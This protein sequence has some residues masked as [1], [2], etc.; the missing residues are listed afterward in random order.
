MTISAP[1]EIP[2]HPYYGVFSALNSDGGLLFIPQSC[3]E[4]F[5][6]DFASIA[7]M[8]G[9][10]Y[11]TTR[12]RDG[13]FDWENP[14]LIMGMGKISGDAFPRIKSVVELLADKHDTKLDVEKLPGTNYAVITTD[15]FYL[16]DSVAMHGLLT[17][18][19][20]AGRSICLDKKTDIYNLIEET[21]WSGRLD[22]EQLGEAEENG[23]LDGWLDKDL[24]IFNKKNAWYMATTSGYGE[25]SPWYPGIVT[26][27]SRDYS[28]YSLESYI[29]MY[30]EETRKPIEP[31]PGYKGWGFDV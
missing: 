2:N 30:G 12:Y 4:E 7:V 20:A 28:R 29:D 15:K 24:H 11:G 16:H 17:F 6:V 5:L 8:E 13:C 9:R 1:Y 27:G 3:K 31:G 14:R 19:R 23:N 10:V 26:Y 21:I 22:G 25:I 18:I